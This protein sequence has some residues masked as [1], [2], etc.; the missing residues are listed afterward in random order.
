MK[1][2]L[3]ISHEASRTGAPI[4]LLT[5]L[6][7]I[8]EKKNYKIKVLFLEGGTLLTE[9]QKEFDCFILLKEHKSRLLNFRNL[10]IR[11][12]INNKTITK[13][14]DLLNDFTPDLIYVNTIVSLAAI[15][16]VIFNERPKLVCHVREQKMVFYRVFSKEQQREFPSYANKFFVVSNVVKNLLIDELKVAPEKIAIAPGPF[17]LSIP[18]SL[19]K[20]P[21]KGKFKVIGAGT[22]NWR[23]GYDIFIQTAENFVLEFGSDIEFHWFGSMSPTI[24]IEIKF[25]LEARNLT[26]IVFFHSTVE[27]LNLEMEKMDLFFLTSREDPFPRVAIEAGLNQ[28]PIIAFKDK[29]GIEDYLIHNKNGYLVKYLNYSE[30]ITYVKK[31]KDSTELRLSLG[32]NLRDDIQKYLNDIDSFSIILKEL[33]DL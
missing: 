23:K 20:K 6:E 4:S 27:N 10:I 15:N 17:N 2:I 21:T 25:E 28:L 5:L 22:V 13:I 24:A 32:E 33:E 30:I 3:F 7:H 31:L 19:K 11:K 16:K 1:N 18:I 9:Y 8:K 14:E 12:F 26:D 29:T